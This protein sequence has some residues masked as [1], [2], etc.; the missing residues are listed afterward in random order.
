MASNTEFTVAVGRC[1]GFIVMLAQAGAPSR[2]IPQGVGIFEA[3][4]TPRAGNV[5]GTVHGGAGTVEVYRSAGYSS[6]VMA[7]AT[8]AAN[9]RTIQVAGVEM[10]CPLP[11]LSLGHIFARPEDAV[12]LAA[13]SHVVR[14]VR[15]ELVCRGVAHPEGYGKCDHYPDRGSAAKRK[16][17][18]R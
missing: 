11:V 9:I 4:M 18:V 8:V 3:A 14:I 1:T 17:E 10:A 7:G 12:A 16:Y 6:A 15:V 13:P 5:V 2:A